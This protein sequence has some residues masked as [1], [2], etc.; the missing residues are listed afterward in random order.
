MHPI[1]GL[2]FIRFL[3]KKSGNRGYSE[4]FS[5]FSVPLKLAVDP[6]T[7]DDSDANTSGV[8]SS[9]IPITDEEHD[10]LVK[11]IPEENEW[12]DEEYDAAITRITRG[13]SILSELPFAAPFAYPVDVQSYPDY[14][15]VVAYP[16]DLKTIVD[17]LINKYYR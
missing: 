17:R 16:I 13:L 2:T 15:S 6:G 14:W 9:N 1:F 8:A 11:Y 3:R 12:P 5:I 4:E 7:P 10:A